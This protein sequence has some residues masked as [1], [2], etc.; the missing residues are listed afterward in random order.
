M[1]LFLADL[2]RRLVDDG[3]NSISEQIVFFLLIP[4]SFCYGVIGWLRN[5]TYDYGLRPS[6]RSSL[7]V[8]SVGNLAAGGTG[9]TPVVDLMARELMSRGFNV[10]ILSR[11]Y[12]G[13]FHGEAGLVSDG[14]TLFMTAEV[15]GDEP[16]LLARRNRDIPVVIARKRIHGAKLIE[17][18]L[19]G[20]DLI[21]LDDGFQHRALYRDCNI[22][23]LDS[24]K[25]YGNG[26]PLPAGCL[27]E[28]SGS[29]KRADVI[30]YTR[31]EKIG[32]CQ[33][34]SVP[35]YCARYQLSD[36]AVSLS[37]EKISVHD[38]AK[39]E[40]VAFAG[41]AHPD[42]FFHSLNDIGLNII[43]HVGFGDHISYKADVLQ[44]LQQRSGGDGFITTE[45]DAVKLTASMFDRPCYQLP[46]QLCIQDKDSL[47]EVIEN[48]IN[49][50]QKWQLNRKF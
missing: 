27:R 28:F 39:L 16:F 42:S 48:R 32:R 17:Q 38:L 15:A 31:A 19:P 24:R 34:D 37:G 23:L 6:Y 5:I 43:D 12:G 45:K 11:G 22:V 1:W 18:K 29:L 10:A 46:L 20:I 14:N 25:P 30:I 26:W 49:G 13:S 2:H 3:P 9:K 41:I 7:P 47:L 35:A 36:C 33:I 4:L 50:A 44:N 40:L 8:V 21:I